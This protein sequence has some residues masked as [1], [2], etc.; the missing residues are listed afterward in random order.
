M[1][2]V[3]NDKTFYGRQLNK[4]IA[5]LREIPRE[6]RLALPSEKREQQTTAA[7]PKRTKPSR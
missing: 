2:L 7:A 3:M 4:D 1:S 6:Y 5:I